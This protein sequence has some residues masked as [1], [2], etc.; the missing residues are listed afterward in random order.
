MNLQK[1]LPSPTLRQELIKELSEFIKVNNLNSDK[2]LGLEVLL[3]SHSQYEY[4]G[5]RKFQFS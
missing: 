3:A 2:P 1:T 4:V 5:E